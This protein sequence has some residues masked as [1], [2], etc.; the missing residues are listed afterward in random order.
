MKQDKSPLLHGIEHK[1]DS[2]WSTGSLDEDA[3][4]GASECGNKIE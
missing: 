2:V 1:V 3:E 4:C